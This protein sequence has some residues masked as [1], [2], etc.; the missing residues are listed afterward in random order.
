MARSPFTGAFTVTWRTIL[1]GERRSLPESRL[2]FWS[3]NKVHFGTRIQ[4]NTT[5]PRI[6]IKKDRPLDHVAE[7]EKTIAPLLRI[8]DTFL[9]F[10]KEAIPLRYL[11]IRR[12]NL[13]LRTT[14]ERFEEFMR[15][16]PTVFE[17]YTHPDERLPWLKLT[18]QVVELVEQ[19]RLIQ[20]EQEPLI[21]ERLRRL[22]MLA[23]DVQIRANRVM[24]LAP[25]LAFPDDLL[26]RVVPKYPQYFNL[27][28]HGK[29]YQTLEL[30]Q[31]DERLAI[32][33]F[34]K[35]AKA[36]A[37]EM[38]LKDI[39]TQGCPL[40]Y[41]FQYSAGVVP[42]KEAI[43]YLSEWQKLPYVSPYEGA[44]RIEPGTPLGDR[45]MVAFLHEV[46]SL[47]I[48]KKVTIEVLNHFQ[49]EFKLP[50]NLYKAVNRYPGIFYISVK[51]A[52]HTL[53]LREA[54]EKQQLIEEH[55]PLLSLK[56]KFSKMVRNGPRLQSMLANASRTA[57]YKI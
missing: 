32:T 26:T 10:K 11:T 4:I 50:G 54:Y 39:E 24:M 27:V 42:K 6:R 20:V 1:R 47:T 51:G 18:P 17:I 9:L 46:L 52:V 8:K 35:K 56:E 36:K 34:E 21:V 31:W 3:S 55:H 28:Q 30:V 45:R 33:E 13:G 2:P 16:Y 5:I 40:T 57:K 15:S 25:F 19:E 43:A 38:S 53:Y 37:Q 41:K 29:P 23:Q 14:E 12:R 44:D 22:L 49:K 7:Q 48:E